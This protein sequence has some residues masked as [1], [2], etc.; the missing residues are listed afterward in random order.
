MAGRLGSLS[1][2][3]ISQELCGFNSSDLSAYEEANYNPFTIS[4]KPGVSGGCSAFRISVVNNV[5]ISGSV[6]NSFFQDYYFRI[7]TS[8][9]KLD[10]QT[11]A[12][13]QVRDV[14][15]W[16]AFP[17]TYANLVNISISNQSNIS[18]TGQ[19]TP[20]T[21]SPLKELTYQV[22]VGATGSPVINS[23]IDFQFDN[24]PN[25]IPVQITGLRAIKIDLLPE[26]PVTETWEWLSDLI[27]S[28]DGTEQRIALRGEVP[29]VELS[30]KVRFDNSKEIRKQ[31]TGLMTAI[32]RFWIPEYQYATYATAKSAIG[33]SKIYFDAEKTDIRANEYVLIK[34]A[35]T[36]ALVGIEQITP[37]GALLKA[38]LNFALELNSTIVPG[39]PVILNDNT[40]LDGYVLN[41]LADAN[42]SCKLIRQR[43]TLVKPG[44]AVA[45][46]SFLNYPV[47]EN[48]PLA[49]DRVK[50]QIT[51][52]QKNIDN[53]TG[54]FD[55]F[56]NWDYTRVG[57]PR[58][59]KVHRILKP[60]EM[61]FW[62]SFFAYARGQ[63][64][65]FWMPT[66]RDDLKLVGL[67]SPAAN[68]YIIEGTEYFEKLY[69]VPT[70]RFIEIETAAGIHR[71]SIV[72]AGLSGLNTAIALSPSVPDGAAWQTVKRISF[73]LPVRLSDDKVQWQHSALDSTVSF[74]IRTAEA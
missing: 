27:V 65:R 26:V 11:I 8:P 1:A 73:L 29:R 7:H 59:F 24:V 2:G 62:K 64:R 19:E 41:D 44:H 39:S 50:D 56:S 17:F 66:Y 12:A 14:R 67:A 35:E 68:S 49:D 10:F 21:L 40:S 55:S 38:P 23:Q 3:I 69:S 58:S 54:A 61:D 34:N 18:I 13:T 37:Y 72:G 36:S 71:T 48:R 16:N 32:G 33:E 70:H 15:V 4:V 30:F 47:L 74:S 51:T 5:G 31:Y 45:L 43:S 52:G 42:L 46:P 6:Q 9:L 25:P 53:Q 63:A 57:G 60:T 28:D 20:Y 22:E